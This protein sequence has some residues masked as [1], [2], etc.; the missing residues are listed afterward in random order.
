MSR[1]AGVL[2]S[3]PGGTSPGTN[4]NAPRNHRVPSGHR[5]GSQQV[6]VAWGPDMGEVKLHGSFVIRKLREVQIH[7][8]G[9][10]KAGEFSR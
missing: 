5:S 9:R 10:L 2:H 7:D 8:K 1:R 3:E 6:G 4:I